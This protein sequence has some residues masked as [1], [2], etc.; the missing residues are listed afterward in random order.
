MSIKVD[1]LKNK[2]CLITGGSRGLGRALAIE[3][4]KQGARVAF[5]YS[6]N[7][8]DAEVTTQAL[9]EVGVEPLVLKGSVSDSAHVT[10]VYKKLMEVWGGID[11]LVNNAGIMQVLPLALL[12]EKDWDLMMSVNVKGAFLMSHTMLRAMIRQKSGSILNIGTFASERVI[13]TPIHYA[14]SKS[15][16]RGM[17]E[18]LARE[19]G[20]YGIRVNLLAPGGLNEGVMTSLPEHRIKEFISQNPL[21]RLGG[22]D[23]LARFAAFLVSDRNT[24]MAGAKVVVDGG[25]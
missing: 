6:R 21:G 25:V 24:F 7:D 12:E 3:F 18:A 17:T 9:K 10:Q 20:R 14:A 15:A 13:E 11:V 23:E 1:L 22:T 16:L 8:L 19:V 2:R 5:T 4:A